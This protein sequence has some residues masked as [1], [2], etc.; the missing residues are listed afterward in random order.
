MTGEVHVSS[1][2]TCLCGNRQTGADRQRISVTA[3]HE[4][5]DEQANDGKSQHASQ[6]P[7]D[8]EAFGAQVLGASDAEQHDHEQEQHD[9]R[10]GVH[11]DLDGGEE[12]RFQRHE[13]HRHAEERQHE[14]ERG[15]DRM[16]GRDHADRADEDH[17]RGDGEDDRF[18]H[19]AGS[20]GGR[21]P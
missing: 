13:L 11:D 6:W 12:V 18:D 14:A 20:S 8:R 2:C 16:A 7:L 4:R 9:D 17:Q 10:A 5:G 3:G 15:V 19:G 21:T 1:A